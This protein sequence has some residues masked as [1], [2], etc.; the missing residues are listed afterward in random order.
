MS[1]KKI[2]RKEYLANIDASGWGDVREINVRMGLPLLD[3]KV[4]QHTCGIDANEFF[5]KNTIERVDIPGMNTETIVAHREMPHAFVLQTIDRQHH[6]CGVKRMYKV[7]DNAIRLLPRS[8]LPC[9]IFLIY[10]Q[11]AIRCADAW[12]LLFSGFM[13]NHKAGRCCARN[14]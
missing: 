1:C 14:A 6:V 11:R 8:D 7:G 12:G 9:F 10:Q 4:L 2:G 3:K 5:S 13:H